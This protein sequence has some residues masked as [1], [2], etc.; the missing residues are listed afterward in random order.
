MQLSPY[1]QVIQDAFPDDEDL[2]GIARQEMTYVKNCVGGRPSD[3]ARVAVRY[4]TRA[5]QK[6]D[7]EQLSSPTARF[8]MLNWLE[9]TI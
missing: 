3:A 9:R 4:V 6:S 8:M 5:V 2:Q 7:P 1:A